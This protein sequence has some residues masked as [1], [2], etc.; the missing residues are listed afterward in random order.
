MVN[1]DKPWSYFIK[2]GFSFEQ[3]IQRLFR[4]F[5]GYSGYSFERVY[6]LTVQ[7]KI[8]TL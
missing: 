5:K 3:A 2:S 6:K 4:L 7:T 1:Y 8:Q